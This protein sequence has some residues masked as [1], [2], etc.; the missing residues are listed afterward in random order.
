MCIINAFWDIIIFLDTF[1]P[2]TLYYHKD[3]HILKKTIEVKGCKFS[4]CALKFIGVSNN[5]NNNNV[6][7]VFA[8]D[9]DV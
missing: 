5:N 1:H 3:I 7:L 8:V 2:D 9:D 6:A 4:L